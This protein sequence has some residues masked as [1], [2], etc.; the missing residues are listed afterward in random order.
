[1]SLSPRNTCRPAVAR[2]SAYGASQGHTSPYSDNFVPTLANWSFSS[3]SQNRNIEQPKESSSLFGSLPTVH[4]IH[5]SSRNQLDFPNDDQIRD[6]SD[7]GP[8]F[9]N[10][11][12]ASYVLDAAPAGDCLNQSLPHRPSPA[13][14]VDNSPHSID[15]VDT[16]RSNIARASVTSDADYETSD[17]YSIDEFCGLNN[18][19]RSHDSASSKGRAEVPSSTLTTSSETKWDFRPVPRCGIAG[20]GSTWVDKDDSGDYDPA[21]DGNLSPSPVKRKRTVMDGNPNDPGSYAVDG[22]FKKP[23]LAPSW[24]VARQNGFSF[25]VTLKIQSPEGKVLLQEHEDNWPENPWNF[26]TDSDPL[27]GSPSS[28]HLITSTSPSTAPYRRLRDCLRS[29]PKDQ[30]QDLTGHPAA[31]G[32][33]GCSELAETCPLLAPNGGARPCWVCIRDDVECVPLVEPKTKAACD[34]CV[35]RRITCSYSE[36]VENHH[37]PCLPCQAFR[38]RCIAG[39]AIDLMRVRMTEDG[40]PA[41]VHGPSSRPFIKCARCRRDKK[42]CSLR[43]LNDAPPC[44]DCKAD[45]TECTFEKVTPRPSLPTESP[46]QTTARVQ[47]HKADFGTDLPK[48]SNGLL[49]HTLATSTA[50]R[51]VPIRVARKLPSPIYPQG[52][53]ILINTKLPHPITFNHPDPK[54]CHFCTLSYYALFGYGEQQVLVNEWPNGKGYNELRGGHTSS[55]VEP[56]RTC[57]KCTADRLRIM[58]C[59]EHAV[60]RIHNLTAVQRDYNAMFERLLETQPGD[61]LR[62]ELGGWCSIC[63]RPAEHECCTRREASPGAGVASSDDKTTGCGLKL[64]EECS[65]VLHEVY[66]GDLLRMV[67]P[68]DNRGFEPD[69][70]FW[71]LGLR[72]DYDFLRVG[73]QLQKQVLG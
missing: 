22:P 28:T 42:R 10:I 38:S 47:M 14:N 59:P 64:C 35:Q 34:D 11:T 67:E 23:R 69:E 73:G 72:A 18:T 50:L 30:E 45:G 51:T 61:T 53:A 41:T 49:K 62:A 66:D 54:S 58:L 15:A 31:R 8:L 1:M 7:F 29:R 36:R 63:P 33:K 5:S 71:P 26:L 46:R 40:K 37:L 21:K 20:F 9:S 25:V 4:T 27:P 19:G 24:L 13:S 2:E 65:L 56:S 43:S 6:R 70:K 55:G 39:P 68:A 16:L 32:C 17:A 44:R 12:N 57:Y 48:S 60:Q 3:L 52:K